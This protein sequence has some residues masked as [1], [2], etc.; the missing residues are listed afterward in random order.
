MPALY[1][2]TVVFVQTPHAVQ[3]AVI[4]AGFAL[5]IFQNLRVGQAEETFLGQGLDDGFGQFGR[6]QHRRRGRAE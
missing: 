2:L 1:P 3:P 6:L 4:I 5:H